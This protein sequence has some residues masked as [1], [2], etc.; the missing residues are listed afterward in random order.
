MIGAQRNLLRKTIFHAD[1]HTPTQRDTR[2]CVPTGSRGLMLRA[3]IKTPFRAEKGETRG[4]R[5]DY[6]K[7]LPRLFR[8]GLVNGP[9]IIHGQSYYIV[10]TASRI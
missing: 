6:K 7:A 10:N 8:N 5:R 4:A 1:S 2:R 9:Y 3:I